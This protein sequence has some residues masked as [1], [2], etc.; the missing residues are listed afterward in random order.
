MKRKHYKTGPKIL[1]AY[2]EWE[3]LF[4]D[5]EKRFE[6]WLTYLADNAMSKY[7]KQRDSKGYKLNPIRCITYLADWCS[8]YIKYDSDNCNNCHWIGRG[9]WSYRW[10][11]RN[12]NAGCS[13]CNAFHKEAHKQEY[14]IVMMNRYGAERVQDKRFNKNK[15]RPSFDDLMEIQDIYLS[16]VNWEL[17]LEDVTNKWIV[18]C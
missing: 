16:L 17:T 9:W 10:K 6:D 2:L 12:G 15:I 11:H 5:E 1:K 7:V 18:D 14:D 4:K 8:G 13:S 3:K